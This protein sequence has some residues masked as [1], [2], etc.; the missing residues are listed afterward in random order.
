MKLQIQLD[1]DLSKMINKFQAKFP[2]EI[3]SVV[4]ETSSEAL[5][6]IMTNTPV[7]TGN[8]KRN[9]FLRKIKDGV[10]E[11]YNNVKYIIWLEDGTKDHVINAK[12]DKGLIFKWKDNWIRKRQVT[13]SGIKA[14]NFIKNETPK[15]LNNLKN[16]M[17]LKIRQLWVAVGKEAKKGNT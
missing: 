15:I 3:D 8:A 16:K 12:T 9:W 17:T 11:I 7:Q 14:H 6:N 13:V 10:W 1:T 5:K 4:R 2:S